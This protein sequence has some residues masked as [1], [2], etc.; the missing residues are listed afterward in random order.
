MSR[1]RSG[2]LALVLGL[3]LA[4]LA[5]AC[6]KNPEKDEGQAR[7]RPGGGA[8][9]RPSPAPSPGPEADP[10]AFLRAHQEGLGHMERFEYGEAVEAFR[11]A[12][13]AAPGDVVPRINLAVALLND[14]GAKSEE[15]KGGPAP[16]PSATGSANFDEALTLLDEVLAKDPGNLHALYCRGVI[17]QYTGRTADA[18]RDFQAVLKEDPNDAK[19]W[20]YLGMTLPGKDN[21]SMPATLD[22]ADELVEIYTEAVRRNPYL[23]TAWFKLWTALNWQ[24]RLVKTPEERQAIQG[25]MAEIFQLRNRLY[26]RN[27]VTAPGDSGELVYGQM[28]KYGEVIDPSPREP[29]RAGAPKPPRLGPPRPIQVALPE[30]HRWARAEDFADAPALARARERFGV[31]VAHLDADRDGKLDLYL[32]SAVAG[33]DGPRDALLLNRGGGRFED[34]SAAFG[35]PAGRASL[36]VAAGDFDADG[37]IDL[38]L[39]GVGSNLLLRNEGGA[40]FGDA[41]GLL[42][43]APAAVSPTARWLDLDQDGDLDLVVANYTAAEHADRAFADGDPPPGMPNSAWRNDGV[44]PEIP[45]AQPDDYAPA[46]VIHDARPAG[47]GLSL[48]LAPW[49][50]EPAE[51]LKGGDDRHTGLAALDLDADRDLDLVLLADGAPPRVALNE[52][53]G[54]FAAAALGDL[55][56]EGAPVNGAAVLH[57]DPDGRAD[58][59]L[60]RPTDRLSAW[61]AAPATTPEGRPGV[62][63]GFWPTDARAWRQAVAA[64]VDLDGWI[65]LLGVAAPGGA[66]VGVPLWSRNEGHRL[67]TAPLPVATDEGG[68]SPLLGLAW[69]DLDGDPLPD[70]LMVRDGDAPRLATNLGNGRHWLALDLSGGWKSG[71]EF[72]RTNPHG[73]GAKVLL[74]GDE[75]DS[76]LEHTTPEAGLAQSVGP[77]VLGLG[78]ADSARLLRVHWPDGVMQ[79]ELNVPA[80]QALDFAEKNL[81]RGSCP[82]LF[83]FDGRRYACLGDFLG[84]GGLG[85]LV[86]PGVYG[87]PDRDEAVA[88]APDQL[89]AVGGKFLASIT[90]PMDEI[91]YLDRI[92][93]EVV[94]RPP[95]V[96]A[97]PDERFAPGGNRPTGA[98]IAWRE[99]IEPVAAS[100]LEGRDVSAKLRAR[101][102][103]TVDGFRRLRGWVGYAEEHGIV[104]DFGDRL[105]RFGP[106]DRLVLCLA[107]W[108]EYPYSQ[109][110]YAAATAGVALAPPV[111][112]RLGDDGA[113][114]VIE[115]DPGY[116]AGM[117]RLTTLDLTGKLGGGRCVLRIRTNMECYYDQAFVAVAASDAGLVTTELSASRAVLGYRGYTREVSPDGRPPLLYDYDHVDPSPLA[118]LAGRLTRY[119][120]VAPLLAEDDDRSCLVGPGDEV[121]LE[122]DASGL[123][124][125]PDGWTRSFVLRAVGYCKD[126]DPF[127]AASDTVGPLPYRGMPDYPFGP[128]EE[129]PRDAA[130]DAYLRE[131]QT[132]EVGP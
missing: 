99:A 12:A 70:L 15:D 112:E 88:I 127:T 113:W 97:H 74:D 4:A 95:G 125:L 92:A 91:A 48:A 46:A 22:R 130:Y 3:A 96:E 54:R 111:L 93:L 87:Q 71:F 58:L 120:D 109:T 11:R 38:M 31:G 98:L 33:P 119:G 126:A 60:V 30:G 63:L 105:G 44:A 53:L 23:Q 9:D 62:Q 129:R 76:A 90:E 34:A 80:D 118:R 18:H 81:K 100:D 36:G 85:Y 115:P 66:E 55:N 27:S 17:L 45:N 69:A 52:R 110:N 19:A 43:D 14:V 42:G 28:G 102:R 32:A 24:S 78:A 40:R 117:P 26:Y 21:P 29:R 131:Y 8:A 108:V 57:L 49:D 25:R 47:G 37:F 106:A 86:A 123:P 124:D 101:D 72:M 50:G 121:R 73:L 10:A 107:G 68:G 84:G 114:T 51:P 104:L 41:T 67:A 83:T 132:R 59:V 77:V 128:E 116:P 2:K 65:D 35:L 39:T 5:P 103:D 7:D 61:R 89:R 79:A 13:K 6:S 56:R 82:V 1:S 16:A 75:L 94:D 122:F 64:D 20:E